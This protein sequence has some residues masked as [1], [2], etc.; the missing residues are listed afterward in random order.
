ML[1]WKI[2]FFLVGLIPWGFIVTLYAFYYRAW[3]VLGRAPGYNHPDPKELAIY[4]DYAPY[5]NGFAEI[6]SWSML[7]WIGMIMIY[8][9]MFFVLKWKKFSWGPIAFGMLSHICGF[10]VLFTGVFEWYMD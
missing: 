2:A 5:I 9:V 7:G 6:W 1:F 3:D 8:L 10:L 4:S